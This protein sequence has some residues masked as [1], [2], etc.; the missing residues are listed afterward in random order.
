VLL[1][2]LK[3]THGQKML[4]KRSNLKPHLYLLLDGEGAGARFNEPFALALDDR[5]TAGVFQRT[6]SFD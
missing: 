3:E 6:G 4:L 2:R 5:E 1:K